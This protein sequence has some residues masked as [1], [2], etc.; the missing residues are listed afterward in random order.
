MTMSA[1]ES[2]NRCS[3]KSYNILHPAPCYSTPSPLCYLSNDIFTSHD[4]IFSQRSQIQLHIKFASRQ[5]PPGLVVL[6]GVQDAALYRAE[7]SHHCRTLR[8]H[9]D[10]TRS[11][12]VL[13][14]CKGRGSSMVLLVVR[15]WALHLSVVRCYW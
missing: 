13:A 9:F 10:V 11:Y 12:L 4:P 1:G 7:S 3:T 2:H 8:E 14:G 5:S 6:A 15:R